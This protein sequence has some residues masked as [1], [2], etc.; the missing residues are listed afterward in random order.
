[1]LILIQPGKT[2]L[3]RILPTCP[4]FLRSRHD[5]VGYEPLRYR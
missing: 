5:K 2:N 1:M 3:A 4:Y